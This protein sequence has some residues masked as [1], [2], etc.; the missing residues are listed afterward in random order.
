MRTRPDGPVARGA[1]GCVGAPLEGARG[2]AGRAGGRDDATA[3]A[4]GGAATVKE[5]V[6]D[7][8]FA[9]EWISENRAGRPSY[10]QLKHAE[11][12][13]HIEQVGEPLRYLFA[14]DDTDEEEAAEA[15]ADD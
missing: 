9:R 2:D 4:E 13:H 1:L 5:E 7:G 10:T 11:E 6:Q 3:R 14:W 8:T 15:A 12:T